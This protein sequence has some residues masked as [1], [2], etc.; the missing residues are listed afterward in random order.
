[1]VSPWSESEDV[2]VEHAELGVVEHED[3]REQRVA[4]RQRHDV[5]GAAGADRVADAFNDTAATHRHIDVAAGVVAGVDPELGVVQQQQAGVTELRSPRSLVELALLALC[6]ALL[7]VSLNL[8]NPA[9][10][11]RK[12]E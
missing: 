8:C 1:M 6:L 3:L 2:V 5:R 7:P 10:L 12:K 9:N 4:E 11:E